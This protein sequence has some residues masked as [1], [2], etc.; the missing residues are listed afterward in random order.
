MQLMRLEHAERFE[1]RIAFEKRKRARKEAKAARKKER[2][3]AAAAATRPGG[4]PTLGRI[5][6]DRG[7]GRNGS[8]GNSGNSGDGQAQA[9]HAESD[10]EEFEM[11]DTE[12]EGEVAYMQRKEAEWEEDDG[13]LS[14][15]HLDEVV[16]TMKY[17]PWLRRQN[18]E[19]VRAYVAQ[20]AENR[21]RRAEEEAAME[22]GGQ[23]G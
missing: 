6:T 4:S 18:D 8:S 23:R 22:S 19:Y 1:R 12:W 5:S 21:R 10:S 2:S 14:D 7:G 20:M 13:R 15:E 17:S 11:S 3:A 9:P 16:N